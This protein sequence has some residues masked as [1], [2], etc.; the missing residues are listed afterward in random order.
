MSKWSGW[1]G[2]LRYRDSVF[3]LFGIITLFIAIT[4]VEKK[5]GDKICKIVA[6]EIEPQ[7]GNFFLDEK[8]VRE[9]MTD[10]GAIE[11]ENVTWSRLKLKKMEDR[12]KKNKFVE[13]VQVYRDLKGILHVYIR[14]SKPIARC[15]INSGD[16]FYISD[17]GTPLPLSN[18]FTARVIVLDGEFV[19]KFQVKNVNKDSTSLPYFELVNKIE[20]DPFLKAIVSELVIDENGEISIFPEV[21]RHQIDFGKP[22]L[23]AEKLVKI[24]TFYKTILPAKGWDAYHRIDVRF[25]DQIIAD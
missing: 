10:N 7:Y 2:K 4:F 25:K 5:F 15:V 13:Y 22:E 16:D 3:P 19:K 20:T 24:R 6:I 1:R 21:G 8:D 12:I 23:I 17:K 11:L 14:Q 9:L 18:R